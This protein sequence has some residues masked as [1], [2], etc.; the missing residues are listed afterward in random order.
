MTEFKFGNPAYGNQYNPPVHLLRAEKTEGIPG[1][2]PDAYTTDITLDRDEIL[3][4][5]D[6]HE[7]VPVFLGL[8]QI[9]VERRID[10]AQSKIEALEGEHDVLRNVGEAIIKG[11]GY[12]DES[13]PLRPVT[14]VEKIAANRLERID[15][16]RRL[17][18]T[19]ASHL[20]NPTH[21]ARPNRIDAG[22][23]VLSRSESKSVARN[24]RVFDRLSPKTRGLDS[25]FTRVIASPASKIYRH[26][27]KRNKLVE[28][29]AAISEKR[30]R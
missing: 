25:K 19:R 9:I 12:M 20:A 5:A 13:N 18:Q 10:R 29:S 22:T 6:I 23:A 4:D 7:I 24:R 8:R 15:H 11:K 26:I 30:S 14:T 17:H 1:L 28:R 3:R 2:I 16:K 21:N 27:E